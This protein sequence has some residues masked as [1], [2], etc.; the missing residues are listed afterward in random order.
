[1]GFVFFRDFNSKFQ[2][3]LHP[4]PIINSVKN[5][6]TEKSDNS[7]FLTWTTSDILNL[8]ELIEALYEK[9]GVSIAFS[10]AVLRIPDL[11]FT[12]LFL[13]ESGL[14]R[15]EVAGD[16]SIKQGPHPNSSKHSY[17]KPLTHKRIT[18]GRK[19]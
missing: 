16:H 4:L 5:N 2:P 13:T 10:S 19:T 15:V 18:N 6:V 17:H 7:T 14:S 12:P 1:V 9:Y 8:T 3:G 11:V